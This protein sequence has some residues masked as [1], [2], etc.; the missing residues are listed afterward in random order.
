MTTRPLL[1]L[2]TV[3]LAFASA[4][5]VAAGPVE[6]Q[7]LKLSPSYLGGLTFRVKDTA[8]DSGNF[9]SAGDPRCDALG[10]G[11][12]SLTVNGGSV[13]TDFTI[14]LPC[15]N[16][17]S[18]N[19]SP[20]NAF[21]TDYIYRDRT[22]TSCTTIVVKH[23]KFISARCRSPHVTYVLDGPQGNIDVT[24]RL[25]SL[26]VRNCATFG[27]PPTKVVKDGSDGKKYLA[28][29]APEPASCTTP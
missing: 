2:A 25:G 10:G 13:S 27:P 18:P 17:R 24:L 26:P 6:G 3:W 14:T 16:W 29:F 11:G 1:L 20:T 28:K 4:A 21:N 8:V 9:G 22:G 12:A 19:G 15:E 23:G 5:P 7:L